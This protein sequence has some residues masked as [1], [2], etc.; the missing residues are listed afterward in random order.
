MAKYLIQASYTTEGIK[1]VAK[2]GG[3]ARVTAVEKLVSELG[4]RLESFNFAFGETDAFVVV[5][6][7]DNVS[8]AA[9]GIAVGVTG[10]VALKTTVLLTPEEID[11]A[12]NM[13]VD[14]RPPGS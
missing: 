8:A 10:A 2:A 5:E 13:T 3:S 11:R 9:I 6:L 14:Y 12:A 4:G 1:G 7:P